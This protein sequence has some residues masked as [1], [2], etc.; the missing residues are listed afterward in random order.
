MLRG[1]LNKVQIF[2]KEHLLWIS[3]TVMI[4]PFLLLSKYINPYADDYT[5]S[6]IA[7]KHNFIEAQKVL[8]NRINGRFVTNAIQSFDIIQGKYAFF[9]KLFPIISIFLQISVLYFLIKT[10]FKIKNFKTNVSFALVIFCIYLAQMSKVSEGL[11]W[12]S[13]TA[14]YQLSNILG[15]FFIISIIKIIEKNKIVINATLACLLS[16]LLIGTSEPTFLILIAGCGLMLITKILKTKK[17][18]LS[19]VI[20]LCFSFIAL[21]I[22]FFSNPNKK[23][24]NI[25]SVFNIFKGISFSL[26]QFI[27][28]FIGWSGL[29][30]FFGII[31][32]NVLKNKVNWNDIKLL[33]TCPLT[34]TVIFSI[35]IV[36]GFFSGFLATGEILPPR[37]RH[38]VNFIFIIG[39][40]YILFVY[41]HKYDKL[42]KAL[43]LNSNLLLIF[44]FIGSSLFMSSENTVNAIKDLGKGRAYR[45][46]LAMKKRNEIAKEAAPES[47]IIFDGLNNYPDDN[48]PTTIC[49]RDFHPSNI[50]YVYNYWYRIYWDLYSIK[51]KY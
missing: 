31:L 26:V 14:N 6:Y 16:F 3:C 37:A 4:T 19:L 11:Y 29:I 20:I 8:F 18:N 2:C 45:Y 33:K 46:D 32:F 44:L 49:P 24:E 25:F 43:S 22:P 35:S 27:M 34:A 51:L 1:F 36:I 13:T 30:T 50:D 7:N 41:L 40:I 5:Y 10:V 48:F 17:V 42:Q 47:K 21:I 9:Y 39:Y 12:W 15:I 38:T 28:S 23:T